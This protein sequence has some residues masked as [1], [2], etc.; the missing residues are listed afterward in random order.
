MKYFVSD[1]G[2]GINRSLIGRF[3]GR[4]R[5]VAGSEGRGRGIHG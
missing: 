5:C 1:N 2:C 4:A 3:S